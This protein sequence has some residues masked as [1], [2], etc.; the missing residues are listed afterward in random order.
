[1]NVLITGA[2]GAAAV[3]VWKS[4]FS[5]HKLF[6][7]D[8]DPCAAGLYLVPENNRF[9]IP[10]GDD[11][12]FVPALLTLCRNHHIE[13]LIPTVDSEL[14]PIAHRKND[15]NK[16]STKVA[17]S[18]VKTLEIC[19][20][21]FKLLDACKNSNYSP[22]FTSLNKNTTKNG[23]LYPCFAKPRMGAGSRGTKLICD[24]HAL[25]EL[26]QDGSYLIQEWLPGEEYSV[27]VYIHSKGYALAAVPRLRMKTDSGVAVASQTKHQP[28]LIQMALD[29]A[30]KIQLSYVA[31]IQ[32]KAD[33]QGN[34]KLLEVN[35]RFP[36]T[37]PLTRAAGVDIPKL[38]IKDF[39]GESCEDELLPF[40]EIMVVRY[41]T[42]H[43]CAI[44]EWKN[45]CAQSKFG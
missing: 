16:C 28:I 20:D 29:V 7:A 36:G 12:T 11:Q 18:S 4:L 32:F 5:E 3:S 34:F 19:R 31:N 8:I 40:K 39:K 6:M 17:L 45:L 14:L 23:L 37:L 9:I 27:D 43:F 38:L 44:D 26:P 21:K 41:W 42:E 33:A 13:L 22:F 30:E 35:P 1:M 2:G 10:P 25:N 15:F 24:P